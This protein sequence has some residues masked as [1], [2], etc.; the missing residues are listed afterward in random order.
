V[1]ETIV[2]AIGGTVVTP[3][4][5]SV[6]IPP[7][8]L[9]QDTTIGITAYVDGA[10]MNSV[11]KI[12]GGADFQPDGLVFN[13]PVTITIPCRTS[14]APG[15][16]FPLWLYN[17]DLQQW[18]QTE[19]TATVSA[20]GQSYSAQVTHFTIY[21]NGPGQGAFQG[22]EETFLDCD[23][24]QNQGDI[25]SLFWD[26][27]TQFFKDAFSQGQR[28]VGTDG[29]CYEVTSI[30]FLLDYNSACTGS[31]GT[32]EA[33][34]PDEGSD[35]EIDFYLNRTPTES[36][37][38]MIG[39]LITVYVDCVDPT[40][41]MGSGTG[42]EAVKINEST[43]IPL[44]N[45]ECGVDEMFLDADR[46]VWF[47]L[48][49]PGTID[50]EAQI[51]ENGPPRAKTTYT[52]N[53]FGVAE[54]EAEIFYDCYAAGGSISESVT[55]K[56]KGNADLVF[57]HSLVNASGDCAQMEAVTGSVPFVVSG[58]DILGGGGISTAGGGQCGD[59]ISTISGDAI[60]FV[61]G[62]IPEGGSQTVTLSISEN[63]DKTITTKCG[64]DPPST[65]TFSNTVE[66]ELE[67]P[68]EDGYT[69]EQPYIGE[70]GSGTYTWTLDVE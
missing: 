32:L 24:I 11:M 6:E 58:Y 23:T 3:S 57:N 20:D 67:I 68:F 13:A 55:I 18:E 70:A 38:S 1:S 64:D 30:D 4:G 54:V 8:A 52:A 59:C 44:H 10:E 22:F 47:H 39:F 31:G 61:S 62:T 66:Y 60:V 56:V 42:E 15:D 53:A 9:S 51:I 33:G 28:F 7:W 37:P 5:A 21:S 26:Q 19:F 2:A 35:Y 45:C 40:F 29:K 34:T 36:D 27:V 63:W 12:N 49:G 46:T 14:M 16:T 43:D 25:E 65:Y 41:L 48:T 69:I 50:P 17:A